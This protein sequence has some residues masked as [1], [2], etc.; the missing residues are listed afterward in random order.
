MTE[1]K[2]YCKDMYRLLIFKCFV[3]EKREFIFNSLFDWKPV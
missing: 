3:C 1:M 2:D